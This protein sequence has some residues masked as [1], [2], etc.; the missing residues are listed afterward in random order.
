MAKRLCDPADEA[1][2]RR[3][4]PPGGR[5]CLERV[6]GLRVRPIGVAVEAGAVAGAMP[7]ALEGAREA[8]WEWN[9]PL[10]GCHHPG[11]Q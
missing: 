1:F 5:D 7:E 3:P 11:R 9:L 10:A 2:I 4:C 6:I 8:V